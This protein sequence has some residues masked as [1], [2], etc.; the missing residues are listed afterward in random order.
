MYQPSASIIPETSPVS[1]KSL[2]SHYLI[3][4]KNV[5]DRL[6]ITRLGS[7]MGMPRVLTESFN[8]ATRR[9]HGYLMI[10]LRNICEE[11]IRLRTN[12]LPDELPVIVYQPK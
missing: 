12:I 5:R 9:N 1:Y 3:L 8:D 4:F 2:N 10:D 6:Q 11:S 7:Q